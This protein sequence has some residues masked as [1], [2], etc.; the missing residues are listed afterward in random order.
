VGCRAREKEILTRKVDVWSHRLLLVGMEHYTL[1]PSVD[2]AMLSLTISQDTVGNTAACYA[3][4][5]L[6]VR[7]A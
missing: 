1:S 4:L 6:P 3:E 7:L 2:T 5:L